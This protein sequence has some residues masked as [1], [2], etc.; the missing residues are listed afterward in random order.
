[1]ASHFPAM[2]LLYCA[3]YIF[4]G[5][6]QVTAGILNQSLSEKFAP[7]EKDLEEHFLDA[8]TAALDMVP[9]ILSPLSFL[10]ERLLLPEESKQIDTVNAST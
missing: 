8:S 1:M 7:E 2:F 9:S 3:L 10:R 6:S 5:P 4:V